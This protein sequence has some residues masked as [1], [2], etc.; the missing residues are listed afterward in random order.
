MSP[1]RLETHELTRRYGASYAVAGVSRRVPPGAVAAA[2]A[3]RCGGR[4]PA[5]HHIFGCCPPPAARAS[6]V[7]R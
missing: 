4:G 5:A 2:G 3:E 6:S 1:A 7:R